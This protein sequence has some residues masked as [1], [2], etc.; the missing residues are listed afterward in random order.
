MK[1]SCDE[2]VAS[3]VGLESCIGAR[4]A[5]GGTAKPRAV[6]LRKSLV[7]GHPA[8]FV[9]YPAEVTGGARPVARRKTLTGNV[10]PRA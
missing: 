1:V 3:H 4:E 5:A 6:A 8:S 7:S 10:S 2:G 9:R